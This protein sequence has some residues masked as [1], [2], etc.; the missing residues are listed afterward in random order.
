MKNRS[1]RCV[2]EDVETFFNA[3]VISADI[4]GQVFKGGV[5]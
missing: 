4:Y 2:N 5:C 1:L 3:V